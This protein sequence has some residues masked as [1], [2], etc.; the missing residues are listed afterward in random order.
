MQQREE[1]KNTHTHTHKQCKNKMKLLAQ[2]WML[3]KI[4]SFELQA[5][6]LA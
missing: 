3:L 5:P 2:V 1:K 6:T 4:M